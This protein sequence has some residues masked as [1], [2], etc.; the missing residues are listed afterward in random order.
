M[1]EM[2]NDTQNET[3]VETQQVQTPKKSVEELLLELFWARHRGGNCVRLLLVDDEGRIKRI[4]DSTSWEDEQIIGHD[5]G[6]EF[7]HTPEQLVK[8]TPDEFTALSRETEGAIHRQR[9]ETLATLKAR[10]IQRIQALMDRGY[11]PV[12]IVACGSEWNDDSVAG[13]LADA[14]AK[15]LMTAYTS[16]YELIVDGFGDPGTEGDT[17]NDAARRIWE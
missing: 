11:V 17:R 3:N 1:N 7:S 15:R 12:G 4:A 16:G 14:D 9:L 13:Y 8:L 10:L 5:Q 2:K 6:F